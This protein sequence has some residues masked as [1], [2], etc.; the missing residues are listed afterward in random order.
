MLNKSNLTTNL[1]K[2]PESFS[3]QMLCIG[4]SKELVRQAFSFMTVTC[5][6]FL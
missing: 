2:N 3:V 4:D 5:L 6:F 1:A